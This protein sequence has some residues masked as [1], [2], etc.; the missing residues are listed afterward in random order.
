MGGVEAW[1]R[2]AEG[3]GVRVRR[4]EGRE[5]AVLCRL[6]SAAIRDSPRAFLLE[7]HDAA[8]QAPHIWAARCAQ[9]D[10]FVASVDD[11]DVGIAR[12]GPRHPHDEVRHIEGMWIAPGFRRLGIAS[13]LVRHLEAFA[14]Q[15]GELA[16]GLWVFDCNPTA[17]RLYER[18]GYQPADRPRQ[19][20]IADFT[21]LVEDPRVEHELVK[22]LTWMAHPA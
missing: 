16:L 13:A 21:G 7:P 3:F 4:L 5:W 9:F 6:R 11:A 10:W 2:R 1:G 12:L 17:R 8:G 15:C 18:L 22:R 20:R 19:Q 14:R